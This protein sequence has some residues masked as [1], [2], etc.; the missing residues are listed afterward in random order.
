[1]RK[2]FI[3]DP[4]QV[5]E[6]RSA[7]ADAILL[8]VAALE[9]DRLKQLHA[10]AVQLHMAALVEVHNRAE[11]QVALDCDPLLVGINNRDLKDFHVDLETTL[12]LRPLIPDSIYVVSESGIHTPDD[13][14]RL[15]SAGVD[16][17]LVGEALVTAPDIAEKVRS[18]THIVPSRL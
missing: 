7:G 12:H 6:A 16:A 4:Y 15:T 14:R 10:L 9:P 2:D 13:L 17:I 5:Y 11:L 8:I 1:L 3:D 18:F